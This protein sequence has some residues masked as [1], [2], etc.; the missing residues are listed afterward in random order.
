M[1]ILQISDA[2]PRMLQDA[3]SA[4]IH[5]FYRGVAL[6]TIACLTWN[7]DNIFCDTLT[8]WKVAVGWPAAFLLEGELVY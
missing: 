1:Y 7:L 3:R 2:I 4:I 6:F 5:L 8:Q